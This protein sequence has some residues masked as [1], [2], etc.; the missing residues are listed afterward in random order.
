[1]RR[2]TT[3]RRPPRIKGRKEFTAWLQSTRFTAGQKRN[4]LRWYLYWC[5]RRGR[6]TR[7]QAAALNNLQKEQVGDKEL[8]DLKNVQREV[9]AEV[10]KRATGSREKGSR[11]GGLGARNGLQRQY[12][13]GRTLTKVDHRQPILGKV[14]RERRDLNGLSD[15]AQ[16][17]GRPAL[18]YM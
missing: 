7:G 15:T 12:Q 14:R 3:T 1:M 17:G 9:E 2:G 16:Q 6:V 5:P 8:R 11:H 13:K 4:D 18:S 10:H